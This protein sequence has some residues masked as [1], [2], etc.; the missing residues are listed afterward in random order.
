VT[1]KKASELQVGDVFYREI[2]RPPDP[3]T[4]WRYTVERLQMVPQYDFFGKVSL[5]L[6]VTARNHV[7]G[8]AKLTLG[9]DDP[10]WLAD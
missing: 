4:D 7:T 2:Y 1:K 6:E 5:M 9:V 3:S 8:P 10:V